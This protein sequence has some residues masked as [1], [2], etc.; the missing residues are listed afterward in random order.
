MAAKKSELTL[1]ANSTKWVILILVSVTLFSAYFF[2]EAISPLNPILESRYQWTEGSFTFFSLS[3]YLLI[4]IGLLYFGGK[5]LDRF[6]ERVIGLISVLVLLG[7]A[8]LTLFGLTNGLPNNKLLYDFLQNTF[9][10]TPPSL[11]VGSIGFAIFGL[12]LELTTISILKLL[13][14]WFFDKHLGFA[15]GF[16]IAFSKLGALL[17]AIFTAD[18]AGLSQVF[19]LPHGNLSYPLLFGNALIFIGMLTF[20]TF[21][22]FDKPEHNKDRIDN[23]KAY[24]ILRK[25][26]FVIFKN[27]K[28]IFYVIIFG[29]FYS[30]SN[31]YTN[32]VMKISLDENSLQFI[33]RILLPL[34]IILF[35]PIGGRLFDKKTKMHK[36][37]YASGISF[38]ISFV[39]YIIFQDISI[40]L[41]V[42]VVLFGASYSVTI[43]VLL[44]YF[45]REV[46][47]K[48]SGTS[49]AVLFWIQ[50]IILTIFLQ[51][52]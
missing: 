16:L 38:L 10:N 43:T 26:K 17:A 50:T 23:L 39:L 27:Y 31:L 21:I 37:L 1:P 41:I 3:K 45:S 30:I 52:F 4:L 18:F 49:F 36:F 15:I 28:L 40:L 19:G 12:G 51:L 29:I 8:Y 14:R 5:L 48:N 32:E 13:Q 9:S 42:A 6:N 11:I 7:G 33:L 24:K 44:A 46:Q 35:A 25:S 34:S 22:L 2:V 20:L 47:H